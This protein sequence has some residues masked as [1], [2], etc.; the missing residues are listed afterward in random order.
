MILEGGL[1]LIMVLQRSSDTMAGSYLHSGRNRD[2]KGFND[3]AAHHHFDSFHGPSGRKFQIIPSATSRFRRQPKR[4]WDRL[5]VI[6]EVRMKKSRAYSLSI[7][8]ALLLLLPLCAR[9][10]LLFGDSR[11]GS[12]AS[13]RIWPTHLE[14]TTLFELPKDILSRQHQ[15]IDDYFL[16]KIQASPAVRDKI[17]QPDFSSAAEYL[18]SIRD[19][20]RRL[21]E[22][23]GLL[24]VKLGQLKTK[25]LILAEGKVRIEE[26]RVSIEQGFEVR[27]L[28][29]FPE[30]AAPTPAVIAIPPENLTRESFAGVAVGEIPKDWLITL[31]RRGVSVAIPVMI[32]RSFDHELSQLSWGA[33]MDRRR[34]LHRV[35]FVVGRTLTGIEVQQVMALRMCLASL[36]EI[37][38]KRVAVLGTEQGGMTAL[39]AAA[40]DEAFA[41]A[42][43]VDY[44]QAREGCWKEP[45]DR[46]LYGQLLSFG[47]AEVAALVAPR[48]LGILFQASGPIDSKTVEPEAARALRFYKGLGLAERLAVAPADNALAKGAEKAAG[49]VASDRVL[50]GETV[51][52]RA[53]KYQVEEAREEHFKSLYAYLRNLCEASD[54][55]RDNYWTL[56]KVKPEDRPERVRALHTE[57]RKLMGVVSTDGVPLNP[58]TR[59][60]EAND[61][62]AAYD[63]LLDVVPGVEAWGHLLIPANVAGKAPAIVAQHGGGGLPGMLTGMGEPE[64]AAYHRFAAHLADEGYV[65]LAPLVAVGNNRPFPEAKNRQEEVFMGIDRSLNPKVRMAAAVGMMRTSIEQAKLRRFIDFLQSLPFV[66]SERIGYYG[67]S[68]GGYATTWMTPLEPRIKATVIS[69]HFNDWRP[70]ITSD[71][72]ATSYLRHPDEDFSNWNVLHRFTHHE[73]IAAM[74]PRAVCIEYGE[75]DA[76]TP[77]G[78]HRRAWQKLQAF[79]GVWDARQL[80]VRDVFQGNHEIHFIGALDFL[81]RWLRPERPAVRDFTNLHFD[82]GASPDKTAAAQPRP[83]S[84]THK[85]DAGQASIVR[86]AFHVSTDS[87]VFS[88]MSFRMTKVGEPGDVLV[89][90]GSSEGC[91]DIGEV[92]I[93]ASLVSSSEGAWTAAHIVPVRLDPGK[94]YYFEITVEW[95]WMQQ[96]SYYLAS[97]PAPLGGQRIPPHFGISFRTLGEND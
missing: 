9:F 2:S 91:Q 66:R 26:I 75:N 40:A 25:R 10:D 11:A 35:G 45:V 47:D 19:H 31:L 69:G 15:Q 59:L 72:I 42:V 51:D 23:L 94:Q 6:T 50:M 46:M 60:I 16:G 17:W 73:L 88:G 96:G 12:P 65:V 68:Y 78:W 93:N 74:W 85:I 29:F 67:L 39:Y 57:L 61:R 7:L 97:G 34:L 37:D 52:F 82:P 14:N 90:F 28:V 95:G 83:V 24:D 76:V 13:S 5:R 81:N 62:F 21:A 4:K 8:A 58:R 56:D 44:F 54:G 27:A 80:I 53:S 55:I 48:P 43:V 20:R 49:I 32:E 30:A 79:A 70:K 84:V 71:R 87:P 86:G 64:E 89:R 18:A 1:N 36:K 92:R 41:G 77:P 22:M 38:S 63:I 3:L 33:K